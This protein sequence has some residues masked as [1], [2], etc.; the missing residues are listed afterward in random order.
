MIR[1]VVFRP[2]LTVGLALFMNLLG[3]TLIIMNNS[4]YEVVSSEQGKSLADMCWYLNKIYLAK[5]VDDLQ[6]TT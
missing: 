1:P 4:G 5:T 2:Y 3:V 6:R